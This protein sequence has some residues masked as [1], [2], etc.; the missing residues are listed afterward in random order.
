MK[1][2]LILA[3]TLAACSGPEAEAPSTGDG[4]G[5]MPVAAIWEQSYEEKGTRWDVT[6]DGAFA[7]E[8]GRVRVYGGTDEPTAHALAQR[9]CEEAGR[10]FDATILVRQAEVPA[11]ST[12][13]FVYDGAC[14][15]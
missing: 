7:G 13:S 12:P 3:T 6:L 8:W 10:R 1:R 4:D 15:A 11:G 5:V 9:G 14:Q 2:A